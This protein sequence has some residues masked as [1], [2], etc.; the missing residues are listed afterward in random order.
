LLS[1][2][3]RQSLS[4]CRT[5]AEFTQSKKDWQS[6]GCEHVVRQPLA[7][8]ANPFGHAPPL[9][10]QVPAPSH[11]PSHDAPQMV[12][13]DG[14]AHAS[15][16]PSHVPAH[17]PVPAHV[18]RGAMGVPVTRVHVPSWPVTLHA[19]HCAEQ[20]RS[21]QKPSEQTPS[22]QSLS[23]AHVV[24]P[25]PPTPAPVE[26]EV[27]LALVGPVALWLVLGP[28]FVPPPPP[29][30]SAKVRLGPEHANANP[31]APS[32]PTKKSAYLMCKNL[33]PGGAGLGN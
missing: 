29:E 33:S 10:L 15:W 12:W 19:S 1:T 2:P 20:S 25:P 13:L 21:Q 16:V 24:L 5:H 23:C 18:A 8:H 26:L 3:S 32:E 31:T 17:V 9:V 11:V 4:G 14:N 27:E 7:P 22:S 30:P 6:L 28:S